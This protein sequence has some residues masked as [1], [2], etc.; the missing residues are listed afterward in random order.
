MQSWNQNNTMYHNRQL[1]QHIKH[2]Y[3]IRKMS[4][5][6]KPNTNQTSIPDINNSMH[7]CL[8]QRFKT[9]DAH[10]QFRPHQCITLLEVQIINNIA[11]S[12][13]QFFGS[14]K[15]LTNK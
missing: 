14:C 1:T 5:K 2:I 3:I 13:R 15:I 9:I 4:Q 7:A 12:C 8:A 10:T 11:G 6:I